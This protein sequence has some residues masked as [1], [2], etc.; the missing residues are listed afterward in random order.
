M[1]D[2]VLEVRA[3]PD[4]AL[5]IGDPLARALYLSCGAA[6]FNI[7][8]AIRMTGFNPSL[9]VHLRVS[10]KDFRRVYNPVQ[11]A[12]ARVAAARMFQ[13]YLENAATAQ[14]VHTWPL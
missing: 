7:R 14:P 11:L 12:T 4:R 5:W 9:Q 8:T 3:D 2:D 10:P 13:R 6:L 1:A